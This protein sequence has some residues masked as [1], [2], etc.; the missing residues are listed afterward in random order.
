ML[1]IATSTQTEARAKRFKTST[2]PQSLAILL[3]RARRKEEQLNRR[4]LANRKSASTAR[5]RKKAEFD[6]LSQENLKLKKERLIISFLP[7]P[8][9]VVNEDGEI[10]FASA[11]LGRLL[12]CKVEDLVGTNIKLLCTSDTREDFQAMIQD[13]ITAHAILAKII[14]TRWSEFMNSSDNGDTS[15]SDPNIVSIRSFQG[16]EYS[17]EDV[18]DTSGDHKRPAYDSMKPN[19]DGIE[20]P[21]AKKTK[22]NVDDEVS[23][24][25]MTADTTAA[26]LSSLHYH[27]NHAKHN[28][29]M[30]RHHR[31]GQGQKPATTNESSS[32][33]SSSS[34]SSLSKA[35]WQ[36]LNSS[37]S[38]YRE[39]EDSP[40][41]SSTA[42][43]SSSDSM[44]IERHGEDITIHDWSCN[45]Y[46]YLFQLP[47]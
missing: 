22:M 35:K 2:I 6:V 25:S 30:S 36:L 32:F 47:Q 9:A 8:V 46:H 3:S 17:N 41:S 26:K 31:N 24:A 15:G 45:W 21:P 10:S 42:T 39:T 40:D 38:G 13:V 4:K 19:K 5:A 28:S 44:D 29:D 37:D 16:L 27:K 12:R 43:N 1:T 23:A 20:D 18:S 33:K 7:D 14:E 11:Q 34:D